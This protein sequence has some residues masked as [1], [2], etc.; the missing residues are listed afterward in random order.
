VAG[1]LHDVL[2]DT[3]V[4]AGEL[5][6]LFGAGIADLVRALTQDPSIEKYRR[7]KAELRAQI[8]DA[9]PD[10]ATVS[11]AD[12]AAKL[13]SLDARPAERKLDHYRATL[14]DIDQQF[15]PSRIGELLRA[16]LSR[17]PPR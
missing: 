3:D 2:E 9:G 6:V 16:Q 11:L 15:G 10:A 17:W 1:V 13:M 5:D 8:R 7:R 12:K 4:S 14:T